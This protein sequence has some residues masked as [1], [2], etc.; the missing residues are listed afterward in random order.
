MLGAQK[1]DRERHYYFENPPQTNFGFW[2][3][4]SHRD[5]SH[6]MSG[7]SRTFFSKDS[8]DMKLCKFKSWTM[9]SYSYNLS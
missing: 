5:A 8:I 9:V 3:W 6:G 4:V 2:F 7:T 1:K